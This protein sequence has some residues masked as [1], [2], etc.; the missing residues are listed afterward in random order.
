MFLIARPDLPDPN[1]FETVVLLLSHDEEVGAAGVII[2]RRSPMV[3]GEAVG[4]ESP[5]AVRLDPLYQGGP[6]SVGTLIVLHRGDDQPAGGVEVLEDIFVMREGLTELLSGDPEASSLRFYAGYAGWSPGQL[7]DEI[8]EG[9][10]HLLRGDASWVFSD[11]PDE[12][13]RS[14]QKIAVGPR[15]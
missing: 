6:V 7:E 8:S 14:L 1:F 13:W 3:V 5:L 12:A 15:V 2:N 11:R 9:V 4:D 10:W